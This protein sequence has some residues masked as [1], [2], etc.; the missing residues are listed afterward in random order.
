MLPGCSCRGPGVTLGFTTNL[1]VRMTSCHALLPKLRPRPS[2]TSLFADRYCVC[3][4]YRRAPPCVCV[5]VCGVLLWQRPSF[6]YLAGFGPDFG[7]FLLFMK[8]SPSCD[9]GLLE[10]H[11][12]LTRQDA[13]CWDWGSTINK[14]NRILLIYPGPHELS[15]D[16]TPNRVDPSPQP[17]GETQSP[18][19][20]RSLQNRPLPPKGTHPPFRNRI[21]NSYGRTGLKSSFREWS[22]FVWAY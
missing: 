8:Y 4:G 18:S 6:S 3:C 10:P 1:I 20:S 14:I 13:Q 11:Y 21:E 5:Y 17:E 9:H 19:R 7:S 15:R 22:N 12:S 16:P 2:G